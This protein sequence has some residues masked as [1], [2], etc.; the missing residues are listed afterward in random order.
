MTRTLTT[1][2]AY[3]CSFGHEYEASTLQK[4]VEATQIYLEW[5]KKSQ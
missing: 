3:Q 4:E 1:I 2:K 5:D